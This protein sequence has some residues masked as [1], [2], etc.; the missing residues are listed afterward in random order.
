[1]PYGTFVGDLSITT[2]NKELVTQ[3]VAHL[4][5]YVTEVRIKKYQHALVRFADL[6]EK[7]FDRLTYDEVREA[8]GIIN[9]SSF[10]TKTKQDIIS[11]VKTAFKYW[12]GDRKSVV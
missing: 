1:M 12:F 4:T 9:K 7:D 3:L 2:R 5:G 11:E 8:G 10:S 6:V